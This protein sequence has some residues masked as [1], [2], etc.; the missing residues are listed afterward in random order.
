MNTCQPRNPMSWQNELSRATMTWDSMECLSHRSLRA[1]TSRISSTLFSLGYGL[2]TTSHFMPILPCSL[3]MICSFICLCHAFVTH[4]LHYTWWLILVLVCVF[5]S[6][7]EIS[8]VINMFALCPMPMMIL[9]YCFLFEFAICH[10]HC[11]YAYYL[12]TWQHC[13]DFL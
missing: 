12:L 3:C 7:V 2:F 11:L 5:A 4:A 9:W 13:H 10:V 1:R 6:W 8:P